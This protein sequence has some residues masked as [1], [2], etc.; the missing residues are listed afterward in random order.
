[1]SCAFFSAS[2]PDWLTGIGIICLGCAAFRALD[3][4]IK[5]EI[6]NAKKE[7]KN[8]V[9]LDYHFKGIK[10]QAITSTIPADIRQQ[11]EGGICEFGK[12]NYLFIM[13]IR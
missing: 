9:L 10:E 7:I 6:S 12:F 2:L 4:W 1:M 13:A 8:I 5:P 11:R 3:E